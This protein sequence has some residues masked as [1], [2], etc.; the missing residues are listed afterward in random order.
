MRFV[1]AATRR[2]ASF[3]AKRT[4]QTVE[5]GFFEAGS[6]NLVDVQECAVLAPP[7]LALMRRLRSELVKVLHRDEGAEI[8][9]TLTDT[10][11]DADLVLK[12]PRSLN[13]MT[14]LSL[15]AQNAKLARLSWNGELIA[16]QEQP[17][18]RI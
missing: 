10:G 12:R 15:L 18:L 1:G 3:K 11:I 9:A 14:Q 16:M 8:L 13:L 4:G 6:H 5:I 2:R 17:T 7:L